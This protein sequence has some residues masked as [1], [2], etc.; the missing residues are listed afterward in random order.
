[1][2]S[3]FRQHLDFLKNMINEYLAQLPEDMRLE[4]YNLLGNLQWPAFVGILIWATFQ[5]KAPVKHKLVLW[6]T[7]AI[8]RYWSVA[9][10]PVLSRLTSGIIP[11]INMGI[12][13]GMFVLIVAAI[14]YCVRVPI[15]FSLDISIPA[16]IL[17]RGLAIT[18]C[19]FVGCCH[20]FPVSWGIYSGLV[21]MPTFP[22]VIIDIV[23]SCCIVVY[24]V[25]LSRKLNFSGDGIVAAKGM[26]LFGMLRIVVDILR[27]NEKL[28][29]LLTTEGLFGIAYVVSG[30]LLFRYIYNKR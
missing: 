3:A 6:V 28:F 20:G 27:D 10:V 26:A 23:I 13:F 8:A 16:Y 17:G 22:A 7:F 4:L 15:L 12:A 21:Q 1:M 5:Y 30:Y 25:L 19:I 24:L 11:Q 29:F 14:V 9:M 2:T 18:G